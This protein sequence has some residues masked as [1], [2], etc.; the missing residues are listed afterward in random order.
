LVAEFKKQKVTLTLVQQDEWEE[1][2]AAYKTEIK[3]IQNKI[4]ATDKEID[5]QVYALYGL[6]KEEIRIVEGNE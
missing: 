3:L 5:H 2:F 6:T 1:Y 4:D